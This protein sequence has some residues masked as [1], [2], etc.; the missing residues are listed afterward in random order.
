MAKSEKNGI[1]VVREDAVALFEAMDFSNAKKWSKKKMLKELGKLHSIW[2]EDFTT[3]DEDMDKLA[4]KIVK[5]GEA[6]DEITVLMER[7]TS[8]EK[9]DAEEPEENGDEEEEEEAEAEADAEEEAEE[10]EKPKK[11]KGKQKPST[12]ARK[13]TRGEVVGMVLK[14]HGIGADKVDPKRKKE[15]MKEVDDTYIKL[16][17]KGSEV[18]SKHLVEVGL[19]VLRGFCKDD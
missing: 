3:G 17:G 7:P 6:E 5:A 11:A 9:D 12:T 2:D 4:L 18:N 1:A 13:A 16:G 15:L 19:N 10:E 8:D 14:K